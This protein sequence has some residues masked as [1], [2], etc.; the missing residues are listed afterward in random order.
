[1]LNSPDLALMMLEKASTHSDRLF[2]LLASAP[3]SRWAAIIWNGDEPEIIVTAVD[4]KTA[5]GRAKAQGFK[6]VIVA[7]GT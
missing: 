6:L 2:K 4:A 3:C 5:R 7:R 1:M